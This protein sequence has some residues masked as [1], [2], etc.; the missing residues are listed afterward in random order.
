M[1]YLARTD[2][3]KSQLN[4]DLVAISKL[5]GDNKSKLNWIKIEEDKKNNNVKAFLI[6]TRLSAY[7]KENSRFLFVRGNATQKAL[8]YCYRD[9]YYQLYSDDEIRAYI[10]KYI[11]QD[12]IY[13]KDINEILYDLKW[14]TNYVD[15][16]QLNTNEY[17]INFQDGFYD[18]KQDKLIPHSPKILSTIQIPARYE[19]VKNSGNNAPV[20]F[21]YLNTLCSGDKDYISLILQYLGLTISNIP[22]S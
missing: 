7:L 15:Y 16:E 14:Q 13:S 9:G 19:D 17:L 11:P 21:N 1:N 6:P 8:T 18:I 12:L 3:E 2:N 22:R 4:K 5:L 10:K 20:F